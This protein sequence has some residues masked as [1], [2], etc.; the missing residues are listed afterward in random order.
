MPT[1]DL[2]IPAR[3]DPDTWEEDLAR[4]TAAGST[5]AHD[6]RRDYES[7]GVPISHL[8]ACEA[9]GRDGTNLPDCLK[10]Y[11]PQ[12]DGK[13]G[14]VFTIDHEAD[15]PALLFLAFGV[16]HHPK[17]AHAPTV[18]EIADQRLNT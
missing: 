14:L 15:K 18:Y 11:A 6:A 13:F 8:K 12:P 16:R 10:A 4:S 17:D 5:A 2:R 1:S 7:G 3:F 9:T